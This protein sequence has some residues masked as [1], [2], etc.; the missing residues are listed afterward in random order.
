[1]DDFCETTINLV[2]LRSFPSL[3][4]KKRTIIQEFSTIFFLQTHPIVR[5]SFK[6]NKGK[7]KKKKIYLL[8]RQFLTISHASFFSSNFNKSTLRKRICTTGQAF[9]FLFGSKNLLAAF[10]F[11]ISALIQEAARAPPFSLSF[12]LW[13]T[14]QEN[15][16]V[17]Q[18]SLS[19]FPRPV[20]NILFYL[21]FTR[22]RALRPMTCLLTSTIACTSVDRPFLSGPNTDLSIFI[23][24]IMLAFTRH[25]YHD[26]DW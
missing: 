13:P 24:P 14:K 20:M 17:Q 22:L 18:V 1:M 8:I 2:S 23:R 21:P 11:A 10:F 16:C 26:S 15:D 19:R 25:A 7:T 9:F 3:N 5:E 12:L 6:R 4:F